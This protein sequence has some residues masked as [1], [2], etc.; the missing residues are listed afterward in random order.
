MTDFEYLYKCK[1]NIYVTRSHWID[2]VYQLY[3]IIIGS[4]GCAVVNEHMR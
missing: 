4:I 1:F 2:A 3:W